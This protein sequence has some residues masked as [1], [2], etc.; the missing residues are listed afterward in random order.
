MTDERT[1]SPLSRRQTFFRAAWLLNK[2]A[3]WSGVCA[4]TESVSIASKIWGQPALITNPLPS[5]KNTMPSTN[6]DHDPYRLPRHVI[7]THYDL[8]IEPDLSSHSF[9][10]HEVA[11]LT[12]TQPTAEIILNAVELD[13]SSA[14]LSG[15]AGTSH[16]GTVFLDHDL[17]RCRISFP[18]LISPGEWTLSLAF[19][20]TLN[21]KLRGFYRSSYKD[22]QGVSHHLAATQFEATDARRA[23]PCWDEPHFKAV[24]AVT[25]VIDPALTAISNSRVVDDRL[26][27]GRRVLRF[28]ESMKMSTYLV[29]FCRPTNPP[30]ENGLTSGAAIFSS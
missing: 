7:P 29:A 9:I 2:V 11:T 15:G 26:E 23:F 20:G 21:D 8:R 30:L 19:R 28:A 16:T 17:Q 27:G 3:L 22:E 10:G 5:I 12:I 14:T 25:L 4:I 1:G 24:F 18:S 13:I 6:V